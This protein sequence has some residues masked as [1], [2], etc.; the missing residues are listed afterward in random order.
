MEKFWFNAT[1]AVFALCAGFIGA[2]AIRGAGDTHYS[3]WFS[4]LAFGGY[5]TAAIG[6]IGLVC[7][8]GIIWGRWRLRRRIGTEFPGAHTPVGSGRIL[9]EG[10]L[11]DIRQIS[12]ASWLTRAQKHALL[13]PYYGRRIRIPGTVAE[14]GEW[15][16]SSS[17]VTARTSVRKFTALLDFSNRDTFDFDLSILVPKRQVTVIGEIAQIEANSILLRNCEIVPPL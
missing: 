11:R 13:A 14:V 15:T 9:T 10:H 12:A 17:R 7:G 4:P 2:D 1:A 3:F 5:A 16:G 6:G 8:L